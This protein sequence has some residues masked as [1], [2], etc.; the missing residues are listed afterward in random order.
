MKHK[1]VMGHSHEG[2][3]SFSGDIAAVWWG[4]RT[5]EAQKK[6]WDIATKE[7]RVFQEKL[8]QFGG[9]LAPVKH[10]SCGDISAHKV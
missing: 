10:K 9:G 6:L 2:R 8:Q 4:T 5:C 7:E 3:A 1:K